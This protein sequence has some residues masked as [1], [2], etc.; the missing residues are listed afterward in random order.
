[1]SRDHRKLRAFALVDSLVM[2]VYDLTDSFPKAEQF[3]LTSQ[4]RRAALSAASNIVEGAARPGHT[5][6]VHFLN[7]SLGSLRELGYQLTVAQRREYADHGRM[8]KA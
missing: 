3:V 1:M 6:F 2:A 7:M 5:E 4:M 8:V